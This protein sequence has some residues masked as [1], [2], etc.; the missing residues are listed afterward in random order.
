MLFAGIQQGLEL[1]RVGDIISGE[2]LVITSGTESV[3]PN[4]SEIQDKVNYHER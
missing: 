3:P 1:L 4:L 2:I